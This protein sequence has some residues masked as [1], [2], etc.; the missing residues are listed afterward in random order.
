MSLA[1]EVFRYAIVGAICTAVDFSLLYALVEFGGM[2][3]L[4]ASYVSFSAGIIVN[5]V[6][7]RIWVFSIH[8]VGSKRLEFLAYLVISLVG[9]GINGG[10]IWL[11][12]DA[13]SSHCH[14]MVS[15]CAATAVTLAWNF[16]ARK[17]L[18]H[19]TRA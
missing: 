8:S 18:L 12:T 2:H 10:V 5:Y 6:L 11:L 4:A 19:R 17:L 16:L 15:K 9:L 14:Y 13:L 7:C 1:R 3:H